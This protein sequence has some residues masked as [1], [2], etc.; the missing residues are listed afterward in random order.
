MYRFEAKAFFGRYFSLH[1]FAGAWAR[2]GA[3]CVIIRLGSSKRNK[4]P[5]TDAVAG[6]NYRQLQTILYGKVKVL[7]DGQSD[8]QPRFPVKSGLAFL[9]P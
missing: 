7:F 4:K 1:S 6:Q 2:H 9:R 5:G 3:L 8:L